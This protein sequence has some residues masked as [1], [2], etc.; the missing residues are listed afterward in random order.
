[1]RADPA[2]VKHQSQ[3]ALVVVPDRVRSALRR[4]AVPGLVLALVLSATAAAAVVRSGER[5]APQQA[6]GTRALVLSGSSVSYV[7]S[8]RAAELLRWDADVYTLPGGGISR[9]TLDPTGSITAQARRV[10]PDPQGGF[11]VVVVQG[12]E[13]DHAA[14][15]ATVQT[16]AEHLLDYVRA[17]AGERAEVVLVGPVPGADVPAS[18]RVVNDVLQAV[19]RSRGIAYVDAISRGWRAGDPALADDLSR[20][21]VGG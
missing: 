2:W 4:A 1:V 16:A 5:P 8:R 17:H 6:A 21:L 15:P 10:L 18:L 20:A 9:S 12:G 11:D 13:A 19:A 3:P 7:T 14:P